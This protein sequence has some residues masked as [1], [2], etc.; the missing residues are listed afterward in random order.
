[1]FEAFDEDVGMEKMNELLLKEIGVVII[2]RNEGERLITCIK[3]AQNDVSHIVYVD[4]GSID[5]SLAEAKKL[6]VETVELDMS[7]PFTAARAR[8]EGAEHLIARYPSLKYIQFI[9]GDCELQSNWLSG[10]YEFLTEKTDYA[11]ACGRRR[12]R[13]PEHS[14]YNQLCDLEWNS[15]IGDAN[16]C[17]G[18]ALIRI[19]AFQKVKGFDASLIAGEEPEMCFRL[20]EYDWKIRRLDEEMTRHDAAMSTIGQWWNRAKR[21]GY[22]Y[23]EGCF[24]HGQSPEQYCLKQVL[25]SVFWAGILP[26]VILISGIYG[27][28]LLFLCLLYPLQ[29]LKLTLRY[30]SQL[31]SSRMAYYYAVSNLG[32]KLPQF[33][34]MISFIIN[35]L[36]GRRGTLIEYK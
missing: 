36:K 14:I 6:S 26:M 33:L 35:K 22:A 3:S 30:R 28:G 23:A 12:E 32:G 21:A 27:S 18:D 13:Y 17:G 34:G 29:V 4:S 15:P 7:I 1:V 5:N 2:G 24:L 8:N 16:A 10:A 11:I 20:R 31:S 19:E 9:D 25:S